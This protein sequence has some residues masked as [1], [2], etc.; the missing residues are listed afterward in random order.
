MN[1]ESTY[2]GDERVVLPK[3][4][5]GSI[6]AAV[7]MHAEEIDAVAVNLDV[8]A[9]E[10]SFFQRLLRRGTLALAIW[11]TPVVWVLFD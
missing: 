9:L 7:D 8:A 5:L 3:G 1:Q 6:D 2:S 11:L 10:L 4:Y